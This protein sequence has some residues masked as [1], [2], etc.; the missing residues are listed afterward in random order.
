MDM[1][2]DITVTKY[3]KLSTSKKKILN[4]LTFRDY[5]GMR[6][7]IWEIVRGKIRQHD[8]VYVSTPEGLIVGWALVSLSYDRFYDS[9]YYVRKSHRKMGYGRVLFREVMKI[10][11]GYGGKFYVYP[12][13]TNNGFFRKMGCKLKEYHI[14]DNYLM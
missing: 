8:I 14:G 7:T 13:D 4:G 5:S 9:M 12:S 11:E 1:I 6:N 2:Y 10:V 3:D